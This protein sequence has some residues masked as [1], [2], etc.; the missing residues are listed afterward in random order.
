[1]AE[2]HVRQPATRASLRLM[3]PGGRRRQ[4]GGNNFTGVRS[5]TQVTSLHNVRYPI[6]DWNGSFPMDDVSSP[7]DRPGRLAVGIVGAGRVGSVLGA[8]LG[9]AGLHV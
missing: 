6:K 5:F 7:A 1:M 8:A 3:Q 4:A 2:R 9:R